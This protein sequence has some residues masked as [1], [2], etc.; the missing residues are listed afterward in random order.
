MNVNKVLLVGRLTADPQLK[1]TTTGQSVT[2]LS[3]A[4]NRFWTDKSGQKKEDTEFH[5]VVVWGRQAEVA[6]KFLVKGSLAFIE[7]RLK[8]RTWQDNQGQNRKT[9]EIIAENI[10]LG[11]RPG[12]SSSSSGGNN[13]SSQSSPREDYNQDNNNEISPRSAMPKKEEDIPTINMDDDNSSSDD[14]LPF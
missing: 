11:P 6:G 1:T 4:T 10:Q 14:D 2:T 9:T 8:T 13:W 7:G 5:N 3:I 12:G